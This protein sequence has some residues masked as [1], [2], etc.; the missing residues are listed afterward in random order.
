M[1]AHCGVRPSWAVNWS[2]VMSSRTSSRWTSA[3]PGR[4]TPLARRPQDHVRAVSEAA[5]TMA[6][7]ASAEVGLH[8]RRNV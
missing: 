6:G 8:E 1:T 4:Q 2:A 3:P 7:I 5:V